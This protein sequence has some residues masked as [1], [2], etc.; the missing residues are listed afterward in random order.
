MSL[1]FHIRTYGCQMNARDSEAVAAVLTA[2]GLVD[3]TSEAEADVLLFNTCSVREQAERKALGKIGGLKKLKSKRPDIIIGVFGC[4]AQRLERELLDKM[5]HVDFVIGTDRLADLP[6]ILEKVIGEHARIAEVS[7]SNADSSLEAMDGRLIPEDIADSSLFAYIAIMRGCNRFCSY[8]I[9]PYVRGREKSRKPAKIVE[10]AAKLARNGVREIT[11][12]GQNV[13]AYGLDGRLTAEK[14]ESPFAELLEMLSEIDDLER[15]RFI[16]PHPAFFSD[17][18]ID[19]IATI[20]KVCDNVHLPMQSGSD[21]IL[22]AMNRGYTSSDYLTIAAKLRERSPGITF[23]TDVII[24]FPGETEEDFQ[25]TRKVFNTVEFD[26]AYIFKYSPREGTK[27]AKLADSVPTSVK[28]E[29]NQILLEDL[30]R[31]TIKRN[32]R[33]VGTKV[34]VLVDGVSKRN[35][36][37]W[38]GRTSSNKVVVFTPTPETTRGDIIELVVEKA[39]SSTLFANILI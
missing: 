4:M 27:A 37:R 10:E 11:L 38:S 39:T 9:V 2:E 21:K 1:S 7:T 22:K 36:S 14:N 25:K 30:K 20:P 19:A 15:I 29:R 6:N 17:K 24:G 18:L 12:L 28:E 16:S 32:E 34:S 33:L 13:A 26:N 5:P 31:V 8:C 35:A 3:A 23:S